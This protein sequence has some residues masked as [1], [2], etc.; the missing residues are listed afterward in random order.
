MS[1]GPMQ[2]DLRQRYLDLMEKTLTGM[3]LRDPPL[4]TPSYLEYYRGMA[5]L[6]SG[7]EPTDN[8][9]PGFQETW[10]IK[11]LD[12]PSLALTMVGLKRLKNFRA[13]IEQAI[14][15]GVAGDIIET[16]VWRGGASIMAKAVLDAWGDVT[17]RV[18]VA[19]SYA[20]PPPPDAAFPQDAAS[21]LHNES[22]L[23]VPL[24]DVR[25]NFEMAGVLDE[26]V[27]FLKGWFNETLPDAPCEHLAV[28]RLDGDM[29]ES[30]MTP[31]IALYDRLSP[32]GFVIID[33]YWVPPCRA[34]VH[35][36]LDSRSLKPDLVVVDE[37]FAWFR[38]DA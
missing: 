29:Y 11:G 10:R 19:D 18:F 26:R 14:T 22:Q 17:R 28:I 20:G 4:I 35:D 12:Q 6:L 25:R 32:G 21:D 34:A 38:K 24:E 30:T 3:I 1:D 23:V 15:E 9:P 33:D 37:M 2:N 27:V 16:G 8:T 31:L 7:A 13:L 36:F 5:R